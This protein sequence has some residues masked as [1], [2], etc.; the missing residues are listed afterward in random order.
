MAGH[1][2]HGCFGREELEREVIGAIRQGIDLVCNLLH[3]EKDVKRSG[4]RL[5]M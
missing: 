2:Y 1:T 3:P 4:L 5:A